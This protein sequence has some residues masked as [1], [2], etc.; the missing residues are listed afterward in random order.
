MQGVLVE[1]K[2]QPTLAVSMSAVFEPFGKDEGCGAFVLCAAGVRW[3]QWER[4]K[5]TYTECA[6]LSKGLTCYTQRWESSTLHRPVG[7]Q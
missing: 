6:D 3:E 1:E 5:G 7:P 2:D 4:G